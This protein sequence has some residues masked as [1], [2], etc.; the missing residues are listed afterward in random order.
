MQGVS[1][2]TEWREHYL[3]WSKMMEAVRK[4]I[5][6]LFGRL[7]KRFEILAK[8]ILLRKKRLIDN[9]V[10]LCAALHNMLLEYDGIDVFLNEE[11]NW[12]RRPLHF[13]DDDEAFDN[14]VFDKFDARMNEADKA[15]AAAA[16]RLGRHVLPR[17]ARIVHGDDPDAWAVQDAGYFTLREQLALHFAKAWDEHRVNWP[18]KFKDTI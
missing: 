4:D 11:E 18:K 8:P 3:K 2:V 13:D 17:N 1:D 15:A 5:E 16:L 14:S 10:F 6:C 7:K 12:A 9:V